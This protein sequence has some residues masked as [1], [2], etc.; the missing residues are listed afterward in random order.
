MW[1]SERLQMVGDEALKDPTNI[2]AKH[3]KHQAFEAEMAANQD[4]VQALLTV[5]QSK[6][7][8]FSL[9][10]ESSWYFSSECIYLGSYIT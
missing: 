4:R 1:I 6:Y 5:G 8:S 7:D 2:Q 10:S 9:Y 3:Q